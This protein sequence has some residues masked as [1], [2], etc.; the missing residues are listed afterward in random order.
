MLVFQDWLCLKL[1]VESLPVQ[2]P[3]GTRGSC[4][5]SK[6]AKERLSGGHLNLLA[7]SAGLHSDGER[8][9]HD[10]LAANRHPLHQD[11][12]PVP[13]DL[14]VAS[15]DAGPLYGPAVLHT[16]DGDHLLVPRG[17][18]RH[19]LSLCDAGETP[20]TLG[21]RHSSLQ[22]WEAACTWSHQEIP[23]NND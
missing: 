23:S 10:W 6:T 7:V 15:E 17:H 18:S 9:Q 12:G 4:E 8:A 19:Q 1:S 16:E 14:V 2:L 11:P 3:L 13:L 20:N 22:G 21:V 5:D